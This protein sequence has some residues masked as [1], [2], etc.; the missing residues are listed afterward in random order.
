VF[1]SPKPIGVFFAAPHPCP[2]LW[3]TLLAVTGLHASHLLAVTGLHVSHLALKCSGWGVVACAQTRS[4][5]L[6]TPTVPV[7]MCPLSLCRLWVVMCCN[8]AVCA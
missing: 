8:V 2:W 4:P 5:V 1:G 3:S 6:L 7:G